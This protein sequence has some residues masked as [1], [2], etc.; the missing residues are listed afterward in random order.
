MTHRLPVGTHL[1]VPIRFSDGSVYGTLC[2]LSFEVDDTVGA[3]A[4]DTLRVLADVVAGY[5]E[6]LEAARRVDD[7]R[8]RRLSGV[9]VGSDLVMVFQPIVGLARWGEVAGVEAL[10]RFTSLGEGPSE[11]FADAWR[12]GSGVELET[13]AV[14][15]ALDALGGVSEPAYLAVNVAPA[16]LMSAAFAA[17]LESA[18]AHRIVVEVTEHAVVEDYAALLTGLKRLRR[19]GVRIAIDDV[20]TGFSGLDHILRLEPDIF[21]VDM[22][23]VRDVHAYPSKQAMIAALIAFAARVG[24]TVVAEGIETGEELEALRVLGVHSGQGYHLARPD[25]RPDAWSGGVS[26]GSAPSVRTTWTG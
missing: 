12:L 13:R 16:T 1:S 26:N 9:A 15:A 8:R 24:T 17:A 2:C 18:P 23:L 14:R 3:G 4:V 5:L 11:V 6:P 10:A 20:G 25:P 22:A 21:K 7:E 19:R